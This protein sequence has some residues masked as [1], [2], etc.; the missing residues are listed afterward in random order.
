MLRGMLIALTM[1][2]SLAFS[3]GQVLAADPTMHEV[4]QAAEAGDYKQA[5]AMMDQ[6]LRDHPNSAKAHFVEAELLAKQGRI[7]EAQSEL[8]IAER[9]D[10]SRKFATPE[11]LEK[12]NARLAPTPTVRQPAVVVPAAAGGFHWGPLLLL[13]GI[14]ALI[15]LAIR[16]FRSRRQYAP[17][18]QTPAGFGYGAGGAPAPYGASGAG[19]VQPTGG[20]G[21]GILGGLA[22]GAAVGA[23]V[24]A[25]EALMHRALDGSHR[26]DDGQSGLANADIG[27][28]PSMGEPEYDMGGEDFG[29]ND[30]SSWDDN[31]GG[32]GDDWT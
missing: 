28:M 15:V 24:V 27:A 30:S 8:S 9:L 31:S 13:V 22:T 3:G 32:G 23:G 1:A 17:Q 6:V 10:P 2:T 21:S 20:M 11:A 7:A 12:L 4:Y 18:S 14:V 19:P 26:S 5:Q 25:G 16:A 29:V